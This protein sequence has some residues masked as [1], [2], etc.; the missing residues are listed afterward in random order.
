MKHLSYVCTGCGAPFT[1]SSRHPRHHRAVFCSHSCHSDYQRRNQP[2]FWTRV[3][4]S[5]GC[6]LWQGT[7]YST[8]YGIV[9]RSGKRVGA[10]RVAYEQTYGAIPAGLFVCHHCDNR[11]CVRPDHLFLGTH[12]E[13][14]ADAK[15]KGRAY[16][17]GEDHHM[18]ILTEAQVR[19]IRGIIPVYGTFTRLG[20][21]FGVTRNCIAAAFYG[22]S[23]P[24]AL[25]R[26][27][28]P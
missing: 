8:G 6:W 5:D 22:K 7:I 13:N 17:G 3:A 26:S 21:K 28:R 27:G 16:K 2:A 24:K 14:M 11:A 19:E 1:V 10:H 18:A 4:K 15:A 9:W 20:R 23:W 12:A 25:T